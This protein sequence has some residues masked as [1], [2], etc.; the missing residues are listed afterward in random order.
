[1]KISNRCLFC[2]KRMFESDD[3]ILVSG[4]N[5]TM[6]SSYDSHIDYDEVETMIRAR[7]NRRNPHGIVHR[8]C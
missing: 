6:E 8:E 1:M 4:C 5:P 7:V 2:K 3:A